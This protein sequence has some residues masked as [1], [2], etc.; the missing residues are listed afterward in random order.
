MSSS[1]P[2]SG[3]DICSN[4]NEIRYLTR[5]AQQLAA[6]SNFPNFENIQRTPEVPYIPQ[7]SNIPTTAYEPFIPPTP[8]EYYMI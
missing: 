6:D 5:L 1:N 2:S 8:C 3:C 4:P 7:F